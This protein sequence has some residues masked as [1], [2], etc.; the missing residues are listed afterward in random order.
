[1]G[2]R[3]RRPDREA[4]GSLW[5]P[6][7]GPLWVSVAP[8]RIRFANSR[9]RPGGGR[10]LQHEFAEILELSSERR[11]R[12][13]V[14]EKPEFQADAITLNWR[15]IGNPHPLVVQVDH[16]VV[17]SEVGRSGVLCTLPQSQRRASADPAPVPD[18]EKTN[19][20]KARQSSY[21]EH[22]NALLYLDARRLLKIRQSF[23]G[24]QQLLAHLPAG[25]SE[26][27]A[28]F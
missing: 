2:W 24:E 6:E 9:C 7:R 10:L 17:F 27:L 25:G 3:R 21:S 23:E 11:I 26:V 22:A 16:D 18:S 12:A 28:K 8:A 20:Q 1:M 4:A 15:P 19:C 13:I 5:P 14:D